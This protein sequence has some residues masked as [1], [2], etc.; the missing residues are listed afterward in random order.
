VKAAVEETKQVSEKLVDDLRALL[1]EADIKIA[2]ISKDQ[3]EFKRDV[4]AGAPGKPLADKLVHFLEDK[5][6]GKD[7]VVDK[8][9]MKNAALKQQ[10]RPP[11]GRRRARAERSDGRATRRAND[12]AGGGVR[13]GAGAAGADSQAGE[14]AAAQGGDGRGAARRRAGPV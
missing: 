9:S 8:L 14:P 6:R 12:P 4:N 11:P 13:D 7:S 3:Y 1:E 10:A 2:E 5:L